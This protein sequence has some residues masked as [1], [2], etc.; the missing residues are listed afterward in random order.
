[1]RA[2][3]APAR[4]LLNGFGIEL[5]ISPLSHVVPSVC[6]GKQARD[7]LRDVMTSIA[8]AQA[9]RNYAVSKGD[10]AAK[11]SVYVKST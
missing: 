9:A 1:M 7:R 6:H 2:A 8:E 3:D 4:G 11:V 10:A 5:M